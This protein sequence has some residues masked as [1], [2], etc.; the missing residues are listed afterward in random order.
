MKFIATLGI[1]ILSSFVFSQDS[2]IFSYLGNYSLQNEADQLSY[3]FDRVEIMSNTFR[4]YKKDFLIESY[5]IESKKED[6]FILRQIDSLSIKPEK[7]KLYIR[8][9]EMSPTQLKVEFGS[10]SSLSII[11]LHKIH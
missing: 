8:V 9:T 7:R 5:E 4:I 10:H 3:N 11:Y 1:F 2:L 6:F